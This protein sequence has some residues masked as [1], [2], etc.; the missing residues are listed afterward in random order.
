M[1]PSL[2]KQSLTIGGSLTVLQLDVPGIGWNVGAK[3]AGSACGLHSATEALDEVD[4]PD[5]PDEAAGLD[6]EE[7]D[8]AE[9]AEELDEPGLPDVPD[10]EPDPPS[11]GGRLFELHAT[12]IA[13]A[14][15]SKQREDRQGWDFMTEQCTAVVD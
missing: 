9:R 15:S 14:A 10:E 2:T 12:L 3:S 13:P 7:P 6:C 11:A 8:L 1:P 4:S 5:E